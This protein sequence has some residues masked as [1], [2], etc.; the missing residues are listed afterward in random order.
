MKFTSIV[1]SILVFQSVASL[2]FP[3][4]MME[5]DKQTH[6]LI[7]YACQ[8]VLTHNLNIDPLFSLVLTGLVGLGIEEYQKRSSSGVYDLEDAL[9]VILG[10]ACK[11]VLVDIKF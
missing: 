8:D 2:S 9:V 4:D 7:G 3:L 11:Q 6:A 10:G 5:R 1:F